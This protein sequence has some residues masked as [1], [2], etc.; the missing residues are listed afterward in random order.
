[1]KNI[2][3]IILFI[4]FII[5]L[6]I[7]ILVIIYFLKKKEPVQYSMQN[8]YS[9]GLPQQQPYKDQVA[10]NSLMEQYMNQSLG[11][12]SQD[13]ENFYENPAFWM[14]AVQTDIGQNILGSAL[15]GVDTILGSVFSGFGL[16]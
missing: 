5:F 1:M 12:V 4:I 6:P 16:F 9:S 7:L 3:V 11:Y 8:Q 13:P 2:G 15:G 10:Y 14:S